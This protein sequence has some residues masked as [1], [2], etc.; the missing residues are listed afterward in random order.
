MSNNL[1]TPKGFILNGL[2]AGIKKN[3]RMDMGIIYS[4]SPCHYAGVFTKNKIQAAPVKLCKQRLN[5]SIHGLIVNSGNA[6]SFTGNIG[7]DN[8]YEITNLAERELKID[9]KSFLS[10]STGVIGEYLPMDKL[11]N[12]VTGLCQT[13]L[14]NDNNPY[15]FMNAIFT[16]DT[17]PKII[18]KEILIDGKNIHILGTAKGAGMIFPNMATM[19]GFI[20]TD[21]SI[22]KELLQKALSDVVEESFNSISVDG[23]QSTND[24]VILLSNGE[25]G[26]PIIS[27]ED[28]NYIS[29]CK[30]LKEIA[31]NLS[32]AIVRDGEGATK[33]I[34]IHVKGA[35]D[36]LDAWKCAS[37]I[38]NSLLVKT[39]FFG[40]DANW[41]RFIY[42][43]GASGCEVDETKIDITLGNI[44]LV[45]HGVRTD[46]LN[47]DANYYMKNKDLYLEINL[48]LGSAEKIMYTCDLSYQY[49]KI[50]GEYRS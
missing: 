8:A 14:K 50:N 19:L 27:S 38:A 28:E 33:F 17:N 49:V 6:N 39:A 30:A 37:H 36:K 10:L 47:D 21:I 35:L 31:L 45:R 16:T 22:S 25:A 5:T 34:T 9:D 2:S 12:G 43:V 46:F 26:N 15:N 40:E 44:H 3:N 1:T 29:F 7:I 48:N 42:A 23:D 32:K 20:V 41:G 4:K 13:A 11:R 24:S 18:S